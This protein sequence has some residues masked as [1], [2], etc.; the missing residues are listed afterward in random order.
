MIMI[1]MIVNNTNSHT[2]YPYSSHDTVIRHFFS[3][4]HYDYNLL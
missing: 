4:L 1:I 2:Q 3:D